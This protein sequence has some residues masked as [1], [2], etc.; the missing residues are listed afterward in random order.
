M[1]RANVHQL[2]MCKSVIF[3][4]APGIEPPLM[5]PMMYVGIET[6]GTMPP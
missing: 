1:E 4:A 5:Y 2:G 6:H 3:A